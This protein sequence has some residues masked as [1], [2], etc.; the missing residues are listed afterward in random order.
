MRNALKMAA[1]ILCACPPLILVTGCPA[2]AQQ[3]PAP[4]QPATQQTNPPSSEPASPPPAAPSKPPVAARDSFYA[5]DGFSITLR[6]AYMTGHPSMGTGIGDANTYP[7]SLDFGGTPRPSGEGIVSIP[8][9]KHNALHFSFLR[10]LGTGNSTAP[11]DTTIFNVSWPSGT[12]MAT[13]YNL[14]NAKLSLDYLSWPFPVKDSKFH[15]KTLWEIQYTTILSSFDAP[16]L[17]GQTDAA[18]APV[19]TSGYG[20]DWFLYPSFGLGADYLISK[21]LRFE[22][23]GSGFALPHRSDLW[24]AEATLCYRWGKLE[25]QA[26]AEAFHFKT[27]PQ[28]VEYVGGTYPGVFVGMRW[29]PEFSK[30]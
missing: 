1:W 18:G 24:D 30:H 22:A 6:Y 9:G 27:S 26:G 21:N 28:R 25:L 15:I 5:G 29:Y 20:K 3:P 12:Y 16:A 14:E 2:V 13:H 8:V 19:V 7:S 17:H 11:Q 4:Q 23:R 10:I